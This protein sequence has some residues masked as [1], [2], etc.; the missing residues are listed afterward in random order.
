MRSTMAFVIQQ[1][2]GV[3]LLRTK[4]LNRTVFGIGLTVGEALEDLQR[5]MLQT[6][7]FESATTT[8]EVF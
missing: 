8:R 6:L 4:I 7:G 2:G 5:T 1:S 3:V